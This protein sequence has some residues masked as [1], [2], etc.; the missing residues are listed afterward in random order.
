MS[1]EERMAEYLD[2]DGYGS[3]SDEGTE[4]DIHTRAENEVLFHL[5]IP[6]SIYQHPLPSANVYN[7]VQLQT[8]RERLQW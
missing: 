2:S 6:S 7:F 3:D 5:Q 8:T 4:R 1:Q